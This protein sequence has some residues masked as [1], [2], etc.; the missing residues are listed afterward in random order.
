MSRMIIDLSQPMNEE[1][2]RVFHPLRLDM[3]RVSFISETIKFPI[4]PHNE[5]SQPNTA[6]AAAGCA[7]SGIKEPTEEHP[8]GRVIL[9]SL[10]C[11][12]SATGNVKSSEADIK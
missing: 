4:A 1:G 3:H 11:A 12:P 7:G 5:Y 2:C 8:N 6:R 10:T 9:L